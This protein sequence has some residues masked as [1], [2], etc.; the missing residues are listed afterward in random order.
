MWW[1]DLTARRDAVQAALQESEIDASAV[2]E[3]GASIEGPVRLGAGARVCAGAIVRGPV[4]IGEGTMIGNGAVVRGPTSI[5]RNCRIGLGV[6]VKAS[7]IADDV[8]LGPQSYVGDSLIERRAYFGA[9]VRTSNHRLDGKNVTA[10]VDGSATDTGLD[11][12]GCHVGAGAAIGIHCVILP[13]RTVSPDTIF[14]PGIIIEKNL[15]A[16]RYR[17]PQNL[18]F[19][20]RL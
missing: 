10:M 18:I 11:K 1:T 2:V 12:L 20:E 6:E 7:V 15:P 4:E 8:S 17:L 16:G 14:G 3:P 19:E 9:Q 13:G 5:G